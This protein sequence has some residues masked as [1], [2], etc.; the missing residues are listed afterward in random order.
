MTHPRTRTLA[1][2]IYKRGN[3]YYLDYK[4]ETGKRIRRPARSGSQV[5]LEA[6]GGPENGA[7]SGWEN[8]AWTDIGTGATNWGR[9]P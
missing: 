9:S 4:D 7:R 6:P 3:S 5:D 8:D 1:R 2:E